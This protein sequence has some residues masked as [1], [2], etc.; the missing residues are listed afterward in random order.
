LEGECCDSRRE[1]HPGP[2]HP[3]EDRLRAVLSRAIRAFVLS[4]AAA[5]LWAAPASAAPFVNGEFPV[6]SIET[7]S[8]IAAGPDGNMWV[9]L[10]DGTNNVAKITPEGAVEEFDL[11]EVEFPSGITGGPDGMVWV[12]ETNHVVEFSPSNPTG[13]TNRTQINDIATS[14]SIVTGPDG[15]L[16]VATKDNLIKVPPDAPDSFQAFEIAGLEP[17]DIDVAGGNLVVADNGGKRIVVASTAGTVLTDYPAE[18]GTQG[19]AGNAA[20]QIAFSQP[21][22]DPQALAL[23]IPPGPPLLTTQGPTDPFGVAL[24]ADGAFWFPRFN[25]SS[26]ARLTSENQFS[27]VGS[28]AEGSGPRQI[29]AGPGN[30]LWVTLQLANK[31]GRISGVDPPA[32]P[33]VTGKAPQTKIDKGP[34]K[35]VTTTG[36]RAKVTFRFSSPDAG[37]GFECALTKLKKPKKGKKAKQPKPKFK[38]CKSPKSYKLKPGKYRFEVRA[39]LAGVIDASPA[40]KTFTVVRKKPKKRR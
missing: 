29:A 40:R 35:K 12:T 4:V 1:Y 25:L 21:T 22:S 26:V 39:T 10:N 7:N 38:G 23:V 16:W 34:K 3:G 15:N 28:F 8:K 37:A 5:A 32:L 17:K 19:V 2:S 36:K 24:G 33:P 27:E 14:H 9:T 6:S 30:T 13:T 31:V 11:P 18:G 20:G